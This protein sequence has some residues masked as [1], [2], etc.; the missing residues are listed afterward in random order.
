MIERGSRDVLAT[1]DWYCEETEIACQFKI[2]F[3][4]F[5]GPASQGYHS[6]CSVLLP[7]IS[8]ER[9]T[10]RVKK[11]NNN[12]D[13]VK[14]QGFSLGETN[15]HQMLAQTRPLR[16]VSL[17]LEL[18]KHVPPGTGLGAGSGNAAALWRW[19]AQRGWTKAEH[20]A[21]AGSDGF[22][23]GA[24]GEAFLMQGRGEVLTPLPSVPFWAMIL[25]PPWQS[26][27][28]EAFA[29]LDR[30]GALSLE[31]AKERSLSLWQRFCAG[32]TLGLL[33]N[34]FLAVQGGSPA[35]YFE[36]F[37][38]SGARAWGLSGSGSALFGLY[39]DQPQLPS[40]CQGWVCKGGDGGCEG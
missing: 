3:S 19:L 16:S 40:W 15:L 36:F 32:E 28:G 14:V 17:E 7:L 2:N 33:P 29:A 20:L 1:N 12:P 35:P 10:L 18:H 21:L 22:A 30:H 27:T 25:L 6:L 13:W 37:Q 11:E 39:D 38:A 34:D 26:H 31:G 9:L 4:L 24:Q 8:P 5:V 23:L